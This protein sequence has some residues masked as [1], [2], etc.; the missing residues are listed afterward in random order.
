M[1]VTIEGTA[2]VWA[3]EYN[4]KRYYSVS[5]GSKNQEGNWEN[6]R[7]PVRFKS[8]IKVSNKTEIDFKAFPTVLMG[9][10]TERLVNVVMGSNISENDKRIIASLLRTNGG[11]KVL[12]QITDFFETAQQIDV[13]VETQYSALTNDDIPF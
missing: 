3:N 13:P 11:N 8:G 10:D 5:V 7:Q 6:A 2:I 1:K 12:W 9:K 4:G